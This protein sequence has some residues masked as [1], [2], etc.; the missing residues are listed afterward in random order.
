MKPIKRV[1]AIVSCLSLTA[2]SS[3]GS[4]NGVEL[5]STRMGATDAGPQPYCQQNDPQQWVCILAGAAIAGGAIALITS[6]NRSGVTPPVVV[7]PAA[8]PT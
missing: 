3:I 7:A 5:R 2:C 8:A 1:L 6:H 4:I